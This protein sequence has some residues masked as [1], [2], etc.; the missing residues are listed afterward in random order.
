M[1]A[2][3]NR[4]SSSSL[5]GVLSMRAKLVF[6]AVRVIRLRSKTISAAWSSA[7]SPSDL[8]TCKSN[9]ER[10]PDEIR[11]SGWEPVMPPLIEKGTCLVDGLPQSQREVWISARGQEAILMRV[12]R[13]TRENE[14]LT[15]PRPN[16][17]QKLARPGFGPAA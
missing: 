2:M 17:C 12:L 8:L 4:T 16:Y 5:G 1:R 6:D 15:D 9:L 11:T 14:R 3:R 13:R 7:T 10:I